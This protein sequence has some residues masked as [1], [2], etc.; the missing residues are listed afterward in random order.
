[1]GSQNLG[2]LSETLFEERCLDDGFYEVSDE[3]KTLCIDNDLSHYF[4]Y[5]GYLQYYPDQL[6]DSKEP[7][8]KKIDAFI[9]KFPNFAVASGYETYAIV[10]L[11]ERPKKI[12][13]RSTGRGF[14]YGVTAILYNCPKNLL[15]IAEND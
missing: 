10:F 2:N 9:E 14:N 7:T 15:I 13:L 12:K 8:I 1:M 4:Y 5:P 6:G 11:S 3:T